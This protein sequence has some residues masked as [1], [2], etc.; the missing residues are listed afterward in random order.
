MSTVLVT[1]GSRGIGRGLCVAFAKAGYDVAFCYR[2]DE[3]GARETMRRIRAAG[4]RG[5]GIRCDVSS[6]REVERMMESVLGLS[7]LIN[8]AGTALFRQIQDTTLGEWNRIFS[9]NMTGAFLCTRA[10][11]P[12]FLRRGGGC[13]LNITSIWGECG[14]SCE[15]A[16]AAS[17][18]ALLNFTK[19]S[20]KELAPSGIRVNAIACGMI[21][22][23]MNE[24]LSEEEKA[25]SLEKVP[26]G[27]QGSAEE[28]GQAAVFLAESPYITGEILRV[29][30]GFL[31]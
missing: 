5:T 20:A 11:I 4:G 27:R 28:I 7:V 3:E 8:N 23:Q 2:S 16:Y 12:K 24:R 21:D 17:K 29:N 10:A 19:S 22:T 1:G 9:V 6:E 26:L 30:G 31:M 18:A 25:A 15:S 14:A 13:I